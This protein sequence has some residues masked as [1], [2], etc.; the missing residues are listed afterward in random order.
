MRTARL[1]PAAAFVGLVAL[2]APAVAAGP[3]STSWPLEF[4][5]PAHADGAVEA[6]GLQWAVVL[7]DPSGDG[8]VGW[9]LGAGGSVARHQSAKLDMHTLPGG[10]GIPASS[11]PE[12]AAAPGQNG[13]AA[14]GGRWASL[15]VVAHDIRVEAEA[16][17][18]RLREVQ[19]GAPA[20]SH[21][22]GTPAPTG[23]LRLD[24]DDRVEAGASWA[25]GGRAA[26]ASM[27]IVAEGLVRAEWHNATVSCSR[28][29]PCPAG[30][31]AQDP[32]P[33]PDAVPHPRLIALD[34][35]E[36]IGAGEGRLAGHGRAI[37]WAV[38]GSA[39]TLHIEGAVRLPLATQAGPCPGS[40]PACTD[41]A[42]RT[43]LAE[44]D[45]TLAGLQP[46]G[47]RG[48][49]RA[50]MGGTVTAGRL[51]EE[52]FRG[53]A[54]AVAAAASVPLLATLLFA[55]RHLLPLRLRHRGDVLDH[56]R[57]RRLHDLVVGEP[58][59]T[60]HDILRRTGLGSGTA[61]HHLDILL[62]AGLIV[63]KREG[64]RVRH[65]ENHGKH[66][67]TWRALSALRDARIAALH[68]WLAQRGGASRQQ[69]LAQ[70]QEWGWK[71]GITDHRLRRLVAS[72][73]ASVQRRGREQWFGALPSAPAAGPAPPVRLPARAAVTAG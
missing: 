30:G 60:F 33:V 18:G 26:P 66:E 11:V 21:L 52:P 41:P 39:P 29:G 45:L 37:G 62:R 67:G 55:L 73:L 71:P 58:G 15:F 27:S 22:Y 42:N 69:I 25:V 14:F 59:L 35:G 70:A 3:P 1:T 12:R 48:R 13:T 10:D 46:A 44:G 7:F 24:L 5:S 28:D 40:G 50:T 20:I 64:N 38:G 65:F 56:P 16:S 49:L 23:V 2:L 47:E 68:A 17:S 61:H 8:L 36:V 6:A 4:A 31:G 19:A 51:D 57:R 43:L 53:A 34:Y 72:G 63:A 9:E 32:A 54:V